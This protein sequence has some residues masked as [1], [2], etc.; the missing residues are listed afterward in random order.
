MTRI[1]LSV[2]DPKDSPYLTSSNTAPTSPK[3][4]WIAIV[5]A[6]LF[7]IVTVVH[8]FLLIKRRAYF[9]WTVVLAAMGQYSTRSSCPTR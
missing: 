4:A 7:L 9:V 8:A 6:A 2:A 5:F 3:E 1:P